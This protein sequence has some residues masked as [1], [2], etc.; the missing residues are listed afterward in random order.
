MQ[1]EVRYAA[2]PDKTNR[3]A[4]CFVQVQ[5]QAVQVQ[6]V[7]VQAVQVQA[8]QVQ[9]VQVQAVQVQAVQVQA[10]AVQA[11]DKMGEYTLATGRWKFPFSVHISPHAIVVQ[12]ILYVSHNSAKQ[13]PVMSTDQLQNTLGLRV[14]FVSDTTS[15]SHGNL[16]NQEL[17][18]VQ[19]KN[20]NSNRYDVCLLPGYCS[21]FIGQ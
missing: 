16:H 10:Q 17:P 13:Q 11:E 4:V 5:V 12:C 15:L 8:V 14:A 2:M 21:L 19:G 18:S 6:A 20:R 1:S 7:Q 9:A 3:E